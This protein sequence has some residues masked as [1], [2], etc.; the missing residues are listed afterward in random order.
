MAKRNLLEAVLSVQQKQIKSIIRTLNKVM[1]VYV[2]I[3]HQ[4]SPNS[5]YGDKDNVQSYDLE[6]PDFEGRL[7]ITG[8]F[9]DRFVSDA[10]IDTYTGDEVFM[11]TDVTM[12]IPRHALVIVGFFDEE[13][14]KQDKRV[15]YIFKMYEDMGI[16]GLGEQVYK[17]YKLIP[18]ES[19]IPD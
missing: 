18:K 14:Q 2:R 8:I 13:T 19:K 11:Y 10:T 16:Y 6:N 15:I 5:I 12:V 7:L 3:Y 1:G 9:S 17:R 4:I